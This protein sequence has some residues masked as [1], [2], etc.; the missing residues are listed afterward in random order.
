[1][2]KASVKACAFT[3][4][5]A[6]TAWS[7]ARTPV[8]SHKASGVATVIAG[9]K[10]TLA[11]PIK[12]PVKPCLIPVLVFVP[13]AKSLNSAP[14]SVVGIVIWR[15]GGSLTTG[16]RTLPSGL[17]AI[18]QSPS[19]S[20]VWTFS[21]KQTSAIFTVSMTVPPPMLTIK[22]AFA[23]RKAWA[24]AMTVLK[25][26]CSTQASKVPTIC[27]LIPAVAVRTKSVFSWRVRPE[28]T[29]TRCAPRCSTSC[30][31]AVAAAVPKCT[32]S[33]GKNENRPAVMHAP[34]V[35]I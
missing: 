22:S 35:V 33:M 20:I 5:S 12:R 18:C 26:V 28:T 6:S 23:E 13:P 11:E 1:M 16:T 32:R 3:A 15:H 17:M 30:C 9:S 25:G 21:A 27:F 24:S 8:E 34:L 10:I 2:A 14:E 31:N 4:H 7:I 19:C 29:N